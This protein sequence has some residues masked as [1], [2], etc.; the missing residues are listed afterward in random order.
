MKLIDYGEECYDS[1]SFPISQFILLGKKF[2]GRSERVWRFDILGLL[3][4][5]WSGLFSRNGWRQNTYPSWGS[6]FRNLWN[7][8]W[9]LWTPWYRN[10][11]MLMSNLYNRNE[12]KLIWN[13][14]KGCLFRNREADTRYFYV[15]MGFLFGRME[16]IRYVGKEG[17][18]KNAFITGILSALSK[19]KSKAEEVKEERITII[20]WMPILTRTQCEQFYYNATVITQDWLR[21]YTPEDS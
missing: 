18:G 9:V 6:A 4:D 5:H 12:S 3:F 19:D 1:V 13:D 7:N 11:R 16:V 2:P 14:R 15:H 21:W 17:H 8:L 10:R 20:D